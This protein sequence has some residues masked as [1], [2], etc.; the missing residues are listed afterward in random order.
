VRRF[1]ELA[2]AELKREIIWQGDGVDEIG[3]DAKTGDVLV[4]I[5]PRYFRPTEVDLLIGDPGKA[6][7]KLGWEAKIGLEELVSEMVSVALHNA[8][9]PMPDIKLADF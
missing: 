8:R 7:E 2:F 1:V 9:Q 5:D 6:K 3:K 4:K